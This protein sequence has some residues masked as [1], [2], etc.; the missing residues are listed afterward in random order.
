[1]VVAEWCRLLRWSGSRRASMQ[2][3]IDP[4]SEVLSRLSNVTGNGEKHR[5]SC[6]GHRSSS[7]SLSI[8]RAQDGRVLIHCFA[9]CE[10]TA[11]L[12][13]IGLTYRDLF[14]THDSRPIRA[15]RKPNRHDVRAFIKLEARE[16]ARTRRERAPFDHATLRASDVNLARRRANIAFGLSL[17]PVAAQ[18]WENFEPHDRDPMWPLLYERAFL[19]A[20]WAWPN[21]SLPELTMHASESAA[22]W[23]HGEAPFNAR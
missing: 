12:N 7:R 1:M 4:L 23:L 17:N 10:A 22:T 18:R 2:N 6:P 8:T 14:T 19:E 9:G 15:H 3:R 16:A 5:A 20:T 13:A 21:A 11:V